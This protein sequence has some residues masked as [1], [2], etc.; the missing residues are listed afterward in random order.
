MNKISLAL[1]KMIFVLFQIVALVAIILLLIFPIVEGKETLVLLPLGYV[2]I[3]TLFLINFLNIQRNVAKLLILTIAFIR[4]AILPMMYAF[5]TN[6]QLF[7]GRV[8]IL[9][10]FS[11]A[12]Y[13]LLYE[14]LA[15][16]LVIFFYNHISLHIPFTLRL[17]FLPKRNYCG[18]I[19]V[20]LSGYVIL[21]AVLFPQV[22]DSFQTIFSLTEP[23][24]TTAKSILVGGELQKALFTAFSFCFAIIRMMLPVYLLYKIYCKNPRSSAVT[25][26]LVI[27]CGVQFLM[28]TDT[29][30]EALVVCL[31]LSMA[32]LYLYPKRIKRVYLTL[33]LFSVSMAILYFLIRFLALG[34]GM[35]NTGGSAVEHFAQIVNAYFT[36]ID[37]V[38]AAL[39]IPAGFEWRTI[40][41]SLIGSLPFNT[42]LTSILHITRTDK[43]QY[44]FNLYNMAQGQIPPTIGSGCYYFGFWLAPV[45]TSIFVYA[46]LKYNEWAQQAFNVIRQAS[47]QFCAIVFA[48]GTGMYSD[49]I[50]L[51]WF[52]MWGVPMLLISQFA[53]EKENRII[54]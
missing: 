48:L 19:L 2:L 53:M 13:L 9:P 25:W 50:T 40:K 11:T 45:L 52:C 35:Y 6:L 18:F 39:N 21:M 28:L 36:G 20:C 37:N 51:A 16:H 46:S 49:S 43:L 27:G 5:C 29:F 3:N 12:V 14:Y 44:Y 15:I 33:G 1:D 30:A 23:G 10:N 24:F 4:L 54:S 32:Y 8:S 22:L 31:T 17:W 47:L 34:A 42:T 41:A 38:S 26:M 7:E